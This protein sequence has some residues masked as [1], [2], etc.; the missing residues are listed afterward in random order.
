M[1]ELPYLEAADLSDEYQSLLDPAERGEFGRVINLFRVLAN[2]PRLLRSYL[3][4]SGTIWDGCGLD[5]RQRELVILQV[6]LEQRSEYEW[7]QHVSIAQEV[8]ITPAEL[9]ALLDGTLEE[10]EPAEAALLEFTRASVAGNGSVMEHRAA[11][12]EY[13]EDGAVVG[14]V[15]LVSHYIAT[16]YIVE[17][18]DI[19]LDEEFVGWEAPA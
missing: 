5:E 10:F 15:V 3:L 14:I 17:A 2:N 12:R 13:F 11:L 9:A 6:A 7:N 1:S 8:G 18:L 16:A 19:D 4:W